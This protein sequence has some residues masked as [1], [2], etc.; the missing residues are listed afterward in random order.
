MSM[1]ASFIKL[2][3]AALEGLRAAAVPKERQAGNP[4]DNYYDYLAKHGQE[5]A[6]Y[7]WDGYVLATVLPCLDEKCQ[8]AL[9]RSDYDEL[10]TF[11]A[12]SLHASY[13]IFTNAHKQA[14]LAKLSEPFSEQALCDYYNEFNETQETEAGKPMLDG[15]QALRQSLAALD[16][17]SVIVFSVG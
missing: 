4:Y 8:M 7:E 2:P 3:T 12:K 17:N 5:V 6:N 9:M 11:L 16:E 15:I 1:V 13:F 10:G 14:Y